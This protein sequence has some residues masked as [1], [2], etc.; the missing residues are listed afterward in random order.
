MTK[1]IPA[2]ITKYMAV[3]NAN[4]L[5]CEWLESLPEITTLATMKEQLDHLAGEWAMCSSTEDSRVTDSGASSCPRCIVAMLK[6]NPLFRQFYD[7]IMADYGGPILADDIDQQLTKLATDLN[8]LI[9]LYGP[10]VQ[11]LQV[12]QLVTFPG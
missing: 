12:Q 2:R 3:W 6:T 7:T 4:P 5:L 8:K 9:D 10:S 11:I 1:P